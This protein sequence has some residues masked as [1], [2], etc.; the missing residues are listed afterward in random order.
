VNPDDGMDKIKT[1]YENLQVTENA[2]PEVIKGAY[3]YLSQKWHPDKHPHAREK[4]TQFTT[5]INAAFAVLSDPQRRREHDAWIREQRAAQAG[6]KRAKPDF[7]NDEAARGTPP[8]FGSDE[9]GRGTA[10]PDSAPSQP[11]RDKPFV[12]AL[13]MVLLIL[14]TSSTIALTVGLLAGKIVNWQGGAGAIALQLIFGF[15]LWICLGLIVGAVCCV[16]LFMPRAVSDAILTDAGLYKL[17]KAGPIVF[18]VLALGIGAIL[19]L[20]TF[21]TKDPPAPPVVRALPTV[22]EPAPAPIEP[23]TVG[24]TFYPLTVMNQ[25]TEPL[26]F[27]MAYRNAD[28]EM[29][30]AGWASLVPGETGRIDKVI[31]RPD[32]FL[33]AESESTQFVWKGDDHT[34]ALTAV[35]SAQNFNY[36]LDQVSSQSSADLRV[37]FFPITVQK[38]GGHFNFQCR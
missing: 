35:V 32:V 29:H 19:A 17:A 5:I 38:D 24:P 28:G 7:R 30:V 10:P 1:H 21:G 22:V 3:R 4:A 36:D 12:R 13:L 20:G 18:L 14:A 8:P 11:P 6:N 33:Y 2:S 37:K 16:R 34:N 27:A 26:R 9:A 15:A 23:V 25:C 31:S